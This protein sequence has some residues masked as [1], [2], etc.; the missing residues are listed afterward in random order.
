MIRSKQTNDKYRQMQEYR[1]TLPAWGV[2][3]RILNALHYNQ[4]VVIVGETGCGKSTQVS[5]SK[6]IFKPFNEDTDES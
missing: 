6:H 4:V 1:K 5:F 2:G 3:N